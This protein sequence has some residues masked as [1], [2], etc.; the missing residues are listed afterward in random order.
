MKLIENLTFSAKIVLLLHIEFLIIKNAIL[1]VSEQYKIY[2]SKFKIIRIQKDKYIIKKE[3]FI[4]TVPT[5]TLRL[6]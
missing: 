6:H 1:I 2:P 4:P 5:P 3:E